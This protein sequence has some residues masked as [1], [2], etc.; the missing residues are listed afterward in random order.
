L[1]IHFDATIRRACTGAV[2]SAAA[3][4]GASAPVQQVCGCGAL[5][6]STV[7]DADD[8]IVTSLS[9]KKLHPDP[10]RIGP[11]EAKFLWFAVEC[12]GRRVKHAPVSVTV[13]P[14]PDSGDHPLHFGNRPRG[15]LDGKPITADQGIMVWGDDNGVVMVLFQPGKGLGNGGGGVFGWDVGDLE[16]GESGAIQAQVYVTPIP[17]EGI[18]ATVESANLDI[19]LANHVTLDRRTAATGARQQVFL[20]M[21]I[22]GAP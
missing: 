12:E 8:P 9:A 22:R 2:A 4:A 14:D 13:R 6:E 7:I 20:P 3:P 16:V 19:N 10:D 1:T 5:P 15:I 18:L 21:I 17:Q 11:D